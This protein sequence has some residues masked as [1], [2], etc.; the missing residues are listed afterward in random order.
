MAPRNAGQSTIR[1]D[2]VRYP[3]SIR[4]YLT[5]HT[6]F[7]GEHLGTDLDLPLYILM[8]RTD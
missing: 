3:F 1:L 5:N 2:E 4:V 6:D 7:V 8:S